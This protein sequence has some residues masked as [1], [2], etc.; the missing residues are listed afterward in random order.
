MQKLRTRNSKKG[1]NKLYN[2]TWLETDRPKETLFKKASPQL[3]AP[4]KLRPSKSKC[5]SWSEKTT[6]SSRMSRRAR[7]PSA[8]SKW[9]T[10]GCFRKLSTRGRARSALLKKSRAFRSTTNSC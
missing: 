8:L 10:E 4:E 9:N 1:L 6:S 3:R 7:K 2:L 5:S